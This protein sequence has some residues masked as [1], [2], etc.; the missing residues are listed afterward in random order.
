M[1][2][3]HFQYDPGTQQFDTSSKQ[4]APAYTDRILYKYKPPAMGFRR[5]SA[6]VGGVHTVPTI[7]CLAY[8]SVQ[9]ITTS[10]HKPVW[11]LFRNAIRPGLDS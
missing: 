7:E 4:R 3:F 11:A 10:D 2:S 8:D 9:S 6:G 5:G 1:I